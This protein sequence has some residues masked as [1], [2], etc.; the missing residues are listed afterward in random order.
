MCSSSQWKPLLRYIHVHGIFGAED[1]VTA[2]ILIM[3][4]I[5][6]KN[7]NLMLISYRKWFVLHKIQ[8]NIFS[9]DRKNPIDIHDTLFIIGSVRFPNL[10]IVPTSNPSS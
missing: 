10:L 5:N 4:L 1:N 9:N 7:A 8:N 2:W 3:I 6:N